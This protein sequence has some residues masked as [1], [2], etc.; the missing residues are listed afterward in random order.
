MARKPHAPRNTLLKRG[1]SRFSRSAV[2]HKTARWNVK[3]RKKPVPKAEKKVVTKPFGKKG[4]TRVVRPKLRR[5]YPTEDFPNPIGR[6]SKPQSEKLR[7]SIKAGSV[8][9]VLAGKHKGKRVVFLKQLPSGLLLVTGP[10]KL[11]GFPLRRLNQAYVIATSTTVDISG[12]KVDPKFDDKY[13]AAIKQKKQKAQPEQFFA[14]EGGE[15]KKVI[16]PERLADQKSTIN[17]RKWC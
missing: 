10:Y 8:L 6:K 2:V 3:N 4:E 12:L 17:Y 9:I 13:F 15:Q 14:K 7:E 16:A 5:F 11:N 1:L